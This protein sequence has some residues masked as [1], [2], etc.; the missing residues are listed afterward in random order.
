MSC[1]Y[2]LYVVSGGG[3]GGGGYVLKVCVGDKLLVR[4]KVRKGRSSSRTG[5]PWQPIGVEPIFAKIPRENELTRLE[6]ASSI[7]GH[8]NGY[9]EYYAGTNETW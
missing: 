3:C 7:V 2:D 8:V 6:A 4:C 1:V 9:G 5:I